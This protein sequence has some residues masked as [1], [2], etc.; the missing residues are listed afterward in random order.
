MS[1]NAG[2]A[3][4]SV[5]FII[6]FLITIVVT[7]HRTYP[8][9]CVMVSRCFNDVIRC[10]IIYLNSINRCVIAGIS[11][12]IIVNI[13]VAAVYEI[14]PATVNMDSVFYIAGICCDSK[15]GDILT[16][17]SGIIFIILNNRKPATRC[18]FCLIVNIYTIG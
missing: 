14:Q 4:H 8:V 17:Y 3:I 7:V 6:I 18:K 5:I 15:T 2:I 11:V 9:E 16:T 1:P 12:I 13:S 10:V